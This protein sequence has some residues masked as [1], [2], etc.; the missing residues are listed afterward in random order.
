MKTIY[1]SGSNDLTHFFQPIRPDPVVGHLSCALH[2]W[3]P[4]TRTCCVS[5]MASSLRSYAQTSQCCWSVLRFRVDLCHNTLVL[6][7][8]ELPFACS[9]LEAT[10][11]FKAASQSITC[12]SSPPRALCLHP[13][14]LTSRPVSLQKLQKPLSLCPH[15][16]SLLPACTLNSLHDS[17]LKC[18]FPL[19]SVEMVTYLSHPKKLISLV[20]PFF[21][22]CLTPQT[23]LE[24]PS[25]ISHHASSQPGG[26][27]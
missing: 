17:H 10:H 8:S 21:P 27:Y 18:V 12:H 5:P 19:P 3:S 15:P 7:T 22:N 4:C 24:V 14:M 26:V 2:P 9:L 25:S 16:P 20:K 23:G 11:I 13:Q 6:H 1:H